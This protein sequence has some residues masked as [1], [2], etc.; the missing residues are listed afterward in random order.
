[1]DLIIEG[2]H[3]GA[4]ATRIER[5]LN[6]KSDVDRAVVNF[7]TRK[8]RVEGAVSFETV[9]EYI[10]ALGYD[11]VRPNEASQAIRGSEEKLNFIVSAIL[12]FPVFIL[13]MFHLNFSGSGMIQLI[14]TTLVIIFPGRRILTTA[15]RLALRGSVN[16]DTLISVGVLAA[17]GVSVVELFLDT[18][19][20]YFEAA[21][22]ILC[23]VLLGRFLEA[24][25]R[26]AAI[27]VVDSLKNYGA[28]DAVIVSVDGSTKSVPLEDLKAGD[29]ILVTQ[30]ERIPADGEVI[31]GKSIVDE[32]LLS[33]EPLP[34]EKTTGDPVLA[35]TV[36]VGSEPLKIRCEKPQSGSL[37]AR[38]VT[39][40]E[41]A[42]IS[43]AQVQRLADRVSAFFVPAVLIIALLTFLGH[44]FVGGLSV[45][46]AIYFA[47]AVLVVA[48]PCA[49]GLATPVAVMVG[50][51]RAAAHM[52]LIRSAIGLEKAV[53]VNTVV[54][55]KTGTLTRGEPTVV[56]SM[57]F[58]GADVCGLSQKEFL[59]YVGSAERRS[60]HP[61]AMAV[62]NFV[63]SR[64]LETNIS[65]E[66][67]ETFG[68]GLSA[69]AVI[70][71]N[72][73][74]LLCGNRKLLE[75]HN[76]HGLDDIPNEVWKDRGLVLC[77]LNGLLAYIFIVDDPLRTDAPK[78]INALKAV[79]VRTVM[80]TGDRREVA[81]RIAKQCGI[82]EVHGDLLPDDKL[83][84]I[85]QLKSS[86]KV[87]AMVGDGVNDAP[88]LAAADVGVAL[89]N[90]ADIALDASD[91]VLPDGSL[92]RLGQAI[93]I[94]RSTL[95]IIRQNLFW[96]FGYNVLA[97]P[98][99]AAGKLSPMLAAAAMGLSSVS[100]ILNSLRLRKL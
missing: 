89:G 36:N 5:V 80:A 59:S 57:A 95:R 68:F 32:S 27:A 56:D 14:L 18:H 33:G 62:V 66:T 4:C 72:P 24:K 41:D 6:Q 46:Q 23:F 15:G 35:S 87:V 43:K 51:G 28:R 88:A 81:E 1:M 75:R 100:V 49:L 53:T 8:A 44:V 26:G 25:A 83:S 63:E 61:L 45:E 74:I 92:N 30:G 40:V 71:G 9:K 91:I 52:I 3:C 58:Q 21:A 70:N 82:D 67:K 93:E 85:R 69:E 13:G 48:C 42:Q 20:Y 99:A 60:K 96:A 76:V 78:A 39:L 34:K 65:C 77:A 94:S 2:M 16:M 97:I 84:L 50:T 10:Q 31:S 12:A 11:A 64:G 38:V 17:Y 19:V 37:F 47:V 54:F 90:S 86:G 98:V 79:G 29:I 22:V 73:Y 7:A 55:D